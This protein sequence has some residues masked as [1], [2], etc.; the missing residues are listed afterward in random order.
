MFNQEWMHY[1][2][3]G[4]AGRQWRLFK[5]RC[6]SSD[7]SSTT[8]SSS[9]KIC[10]SSYL[11]EVLPLVSMEKVCYFLRPHLVLAEQ[12]DAAVV[13]G[14]GVPVRQP[15]VRAPCTAQVLF[16]QTHQAEGVR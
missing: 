5:T 9:T 2:R 14:L 16:T 4:G 13:E 8:A 1:Q 6:L 3:T 10:D 15:Q 7:A 11:S 12:E